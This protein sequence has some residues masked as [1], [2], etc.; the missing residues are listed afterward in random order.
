MDEKALVVYPLFSKDELQKSILAIYAKNKYA[1]LSPNSLALKTKWA[2]HA[3]IEDVLQSLCEKG[4]LSL[5]N[6]VYKNA[7]VELG[8]IEEHVQTQIFAILKDGGLSPDAPYNIYDDLD[9]DRKMGDDALKN[10]TKSKKVVRLA[11]NLFI[12]ATA[13][14]RV[15]VLMREIIKN[16]GYVDVQSL[17]KHLELSRKYLIAYLDYLD[18]FDD[19][20][21]EGDKRKL[22]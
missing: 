19:I 5:D 22:R 13:L 21:K 1:L 9:I 18:A 4:V 6:G 16:E 20:V 3:L 14:T 11:H 17:K 10:L 15:L 2:S 12:E 8:N 7:S